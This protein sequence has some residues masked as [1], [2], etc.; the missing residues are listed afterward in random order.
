MI[1]NNR[2][3]AIIEAANG[4]DISFVVNEVYGQVNSLTL[5]SVRIPT[6][7]ELAIS[8]NQ[9]VINDGILRFTPA[10]LDAS[11]FK[12]GYGHSKARV[13]G[14]G[15]EYIYYFSPLSEQNPGLPEESRYS[16]D[17]SHMAWKREKEAAREV[18]GAV[19][20][21]SLRNDGVGIQFSE[22]Y[23]KSIKKDAGK[24]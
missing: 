15:M 11:L 13:K 19:L 23:I 7:R 3:A 24:F 17:S 21:G 6:N 4:A 2:L 5:K 12:S 10:D 22:K 20:F 16:I 14:A 1:A 18:N 9:S 8:I